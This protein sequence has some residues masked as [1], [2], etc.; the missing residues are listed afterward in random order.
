MSPIRRSLRHRTHT[1]LESSV[2]GDHYG[3]V[4]DYFMIALIVVNVAAVILESV[5]S[6]G[7]AFHQ[8]FFILE[9]VSVGIFTVEYLARVWSATANVIGGYGHPVWGRIKYMLTPLAIIDLLAFLPI[10]LSAF[11]GADWRI[12]RLVRLIRLLKLTRY[13]PALAILAAVARDQ[14]R[15]LTAA[16]LLLV[17]ALLFSSTVVYLIEREGQP[18]VFSSIPA[19]MWWAM[20]TLTTVGY[21]DV[22]PLTPLG[23][24]FGALTMIMGIGMLAIPTGVIATGFANEIRKRDFVV[25][26]RLVSKVPLFSELDAAQIADIVGILT[27]IVVP[28]NH[29]IVRVGEESESMFFI[30]SG[31]VEMDTRPEPRFLENGEYFGEVG[32]LENRRRFA[33][34]IALTECQLLE[35][36]ADDFHRLLAANPSIKESVEE[37]VAVR[38][39]L[40]GDDNLGPV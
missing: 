6:I 23:R 12:L 38:K 39:K 36:K 37:V 34:A 10:Y 17:I 9:V 40:M 4:F 15:A 33:S 18:E 24:I 29:A 5:H 11:F 35:L 7:T 8:E 26:W 22:A 16:A 31:R 28:T 19:A 25:N 27:P 13:S 2:P 20:A 30:V 21:G 1:F 14:S 3:Y 32:I